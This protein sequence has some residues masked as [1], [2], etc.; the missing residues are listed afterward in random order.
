[1]PAGNPLLAESATWFH[2][3]TTSLGAI[4]RQ[5]TVLSR[6]QRAG[7]AVPPERRTP[8]LR[9]LLHRL[10]AQITMLR[11]EETNLQTALTVHDL[12]QSSSGQLAA[13]NTALARLHQTSPSA[14]GTNPQ[15]P[16][17]T[18]TLTQQRSALAQQVRAWS[19]GLRQALKLPLPVPAP[20]A[21]RLAGRVIT[22]ATEP[23]PTPR[24]PPHRPPVMQPGLP[25][26]LRLPTHPHV[27]VVPTAPLKRR[28]LSAPLI[29]P[30][31]PQPEP[32][33]TFTTQPP[34]RHT[35]TAPAPLNRH[36]RRPLTDATHTKP[37]IAPATDTDT[38]TDQ[39]RTASAHAEPTGDH[40]TAGTLTTRRQPGSVHDKSAHDSTATPEHEKA[41]DT[42]HD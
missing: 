25:R 35:A 41:E 14:A 12:Y 10:A 26:K 19:S 18:T 3:A 9:A 13:L 29:L 40:H 2:Q 7:R 15:V 37:A 21:T 28:H 36:I 42:D 31:H 5:L 30:R 8:R 22:A 1:M 33:T 4:N 23:P 24:T 20:A 34:A 11:H 39:C 16:Q 27:P 17:L 6:A 38:D 32:A